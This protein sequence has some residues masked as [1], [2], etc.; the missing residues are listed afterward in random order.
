MVLNDLND[1][2]IQTLI[3][4][5]KTPEE[6]LK[7]VMVLISAL[8]AVRDIALAESLETDPAR[9]LRIS[10]LLELSVGDNE[11]ES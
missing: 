5:A 1:F 8:A 6:F 9:Y 3:R 2:K 10:E 7:I 4:S 11:N